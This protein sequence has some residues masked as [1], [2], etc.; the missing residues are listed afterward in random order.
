MLAPFKG[1]F[2]QVSAQ[3]SQ[4]S[5]IWPSPQSY[6]PTLAPSYDFAASVYLPD[7]GRGLQVDGALLGSHDCNSSLIAEQ[8]SSTR[9]D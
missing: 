6:P 2:L 1:L 9:S 4:S 3:F 8:L 5:S 7:T